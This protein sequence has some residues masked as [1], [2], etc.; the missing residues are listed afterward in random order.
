MVSTKDGVDHCAIHFISN[1]SQKKACQKCMKDLFVNWGCMP[2]N[3][4]TFERLFT[5]SLLPHSKLSAILSE[6]KKALQVTN[7]DYD[8]VTKQLDLY[9]DMKLVTFDIDEDRNLIVQFPVFVQPYMQQLLTL[10]Q[11]ETV[12]VLIVDQNKQ[13]ESYTHLQIVKT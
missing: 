8:M 12:P 11:I 4:N 13:A 10:Y 5:I 9:Y 2:G 6:G 3:K 7:Q 1:H